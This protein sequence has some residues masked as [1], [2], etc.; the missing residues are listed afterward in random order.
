MLPDSTDPRMPEGHEARRP[1]WADHAAR[2]PCDAPASPTR[3]PRRVRGAEQWE[4]RRRRRERITAAPS[5]APA[6]GETTT[7]QR[8]DPG[9]SE[10][11]QASGAVTA[12]AD[13][14]AYSARF[15]AKFT[16]DPFIRPP[17]IDCTDR[18]CAHVPRDDGL[19]PIESVNRNHG[20]IPHSAQAGGKR[21]AATAT[22]RSRSA[23]RP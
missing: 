18:P 8:V 4:A 12:I 11:F 2:P 14:L 23:P 15:H 20:T 13:P 19:G 1:R 16:R 22:A 17:G 21:P 10:A 7:T 9:I 5:A 6:G 3:P